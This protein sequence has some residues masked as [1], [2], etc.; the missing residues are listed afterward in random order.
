MRTLRRK[1]VRF[2]YQTN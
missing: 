2:D 1:L